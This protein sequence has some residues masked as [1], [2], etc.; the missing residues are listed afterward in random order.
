MHLLRHPARIIFGSTVLNRRRLIYEEA[1]VIFA[2]LT[3][4][5]TKRAVEISTERTVIRYTVA[6]ENRAARAKLVVSR[7]RSFQRA[8]IHVFNI[9]E[10][11]A[12]SLIIYVG[13]ITGNYRGSR[14]VA[15]NLA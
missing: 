10:Q 12:Y 14:L 13:T 7:N 11:S 6:S 9:S 8:L 3:E 15:L 4:T 1:S 5:K 2:I